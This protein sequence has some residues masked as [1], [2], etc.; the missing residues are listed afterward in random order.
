MLLHNRIATVSREDQVFQERDIDGVKRTCKR[1]GD[2]NVTGGRQCKPLR[3]VMRQNDSGRFSK[4][5]LLRHQADRNRGAADN[6]FRHQHA[7]NHIQPIVEKHHVKA[8][9]IQSD[10][11][12][13]KEIRQ[14]LE[15]VVHLC[16]RDFLHRIAL[17]Q[18]GN[19]LEQ[20]CRLRTDSVAQKQFVKR[21]LADSLERSEP[22]H[23]SVRHTVGIDARNGIVQQHFEKLVRCK[24]V[25]S[26]L[27]T[28]L[29]HP[30]SVVLMQGS[31]PP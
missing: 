5:R 28:P 10:K 7:V 22:L 17:H 26:V 3:V 16:R 25:K 15:I 8:F 4:Q 31:S 27:Q 29:P 19:Q 20:N 11:L 23:Q 30:F 24:V 12:T 13:G 9:M 2:C 21:S 1:F 14:L 18:F 6:A